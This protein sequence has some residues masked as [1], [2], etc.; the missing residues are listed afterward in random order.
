MKLT[1][2]VIIPRDKLTRYLLVFQPENDK[3]KFLAQAGFTQENPDALEA[4]IRDLIA[5]HDAVLDRQD[6]FGD[7]YRV[8]GTLRGVNDHHLAVVTI[9]IVR[10]EEADVYRFVTLKPWR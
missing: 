2:D 8:E 1:S 5:H 10:T 4:A 7:F 3:S 6:Y 9:W